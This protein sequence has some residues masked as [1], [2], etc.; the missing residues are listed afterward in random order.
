MYEDEDSLCRL[1]RRLSIGSSRNTCM[2]VLKGWAIPTTGTDLFNF[3]SS[4]IVCTCREMSKMEEDPMI[5]QV[6]K[7]NIL[8]TTQFLVLVYLFTFFCRECV[9]SQ[10]HSCA[11][12]RFQAIISIHLK[13]LKVFKVFAELKFQTFSRIKVEIVECFMSTTVPL[14]G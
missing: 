2:A 13:A 1:T 4:L 11:P 12:K 14:G 10:E 6:Q 9:T 3:F 7:C 8:F 5:P